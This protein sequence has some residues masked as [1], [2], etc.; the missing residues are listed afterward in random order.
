M[1]NLFKTAAL[2]ALIGLGGIAA[3]PSTAAADGIYFSFGARDGGVVGVQ[4]DRRDGM[5][6]VEP[7]GGCSARE[8]LNKAER[9]GL[10]RVYVRSQNRNVIRVSGR[11][12]GGMDTVVFANAR[13]CPVIR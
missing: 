5:R 6:R 13:G 11:V 9:M 4:Y 2:S 1:K 12:R 3:L 8:A 10:R 7:R